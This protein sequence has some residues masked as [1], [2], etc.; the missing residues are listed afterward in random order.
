MLAV[1]RARARPLGVGLAKHRILARVQPPAPFGVGQPEGEAAGR[2][3]GAAAGQGDGDAG[4]HRGAAEAEKG[5]SVDLHGAA[6][7]A[8]RP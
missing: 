8:R 6:F 4:D 2:G 3:V 5:A 1:E 7:C